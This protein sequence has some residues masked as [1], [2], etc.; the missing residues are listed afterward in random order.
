MIEVI[1]DLFEVDDSITIVGSA[2]WYLSGVDKSPKDIDIIVDDTTRLETILDIKKYQANGLY[3]L[4]TKRA[5]ARYKGY[6]IDIFIGE[7][8][9]DTEIKNVDGVDIRYQTMKGYIEY[10]ERTILKKGNHQN[11]GVLLDKIRQAQN[12][13]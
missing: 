6:L 10:C 7:T 1:K 8:S 9:A 11:R 2:G 3:S 4:T 12:Y 5:Y 13:I